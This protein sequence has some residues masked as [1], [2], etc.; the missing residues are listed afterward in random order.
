M[1]TKESAELGQVAQRSRGRRATV[2]VVA[3]IVT[4]GVAALAWIMTSAGPVPAEEAQIEITFSGDGT[5]FVGDREI[6][7]GTATVTFSN[8]TDGRA[9]LVVLGYET[10]SAALAEELGVMAEG[11]SVV[12]SNAPTA[13]FS[14]IEFEGQNDL[15]PGSHSWTMDLEPG[16]TYL[17]DVGPEGF[18]TK[19]IWRAA[20]IEVVAK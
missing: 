2:V 19:G 18:H 6:I 20:I 12:T 17:V 10:G 5:S 16:N 7:E 13:G 3:I 8:E 14:E 11:S 15:V 4:V 9:I 1:L